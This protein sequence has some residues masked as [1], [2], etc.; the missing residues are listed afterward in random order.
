MIPDTSAYLRLLLDIYQKNKE[1]VVLNT[2]ITQ[3]FIKVLRKS[4][5]TLNEQ[6][7]REL[8]ENLIKR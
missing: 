4:S 6:E 5:D 1:E 3:E 2:L 8:W 7:V